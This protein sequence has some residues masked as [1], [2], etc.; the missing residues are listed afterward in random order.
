MKV[1]DADDF[2]S[3]HVISDQCQS[4]DCRDVLDRLHYI[5]SN[6]KVT[7]FAIP[8]EMTYELAEW[9]HTNDSW[10]ELAIHGI[11]HSSNY[12]C[13]KMTYQEFDQAIEELQPMI[14]NYFTK[15]FKAPGWQI[16]E[17][18]YQWLDDNDYWVA[19]QGYNDN[20]RPGS[21][22]VYLNNSGNFSAIPRVGNPV[23]VDGIHTHT[24][25]CVGNGIYELEDQLIEQIKGESEFRFISEL[26]S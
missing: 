14:D 11:F 23:A 25:N 10:I 18:V 17:E 3:N 2:G 4:H 16:G 12:E 9:C 8:A 22:P 5:N 13:D 24:W 19:D 1:F 20:R 15:G 21:L 26:L 7:L 6:F